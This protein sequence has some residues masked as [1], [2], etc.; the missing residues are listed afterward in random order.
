MCEPLTAHVVEVAR[1]NG[2]VSIQVL[3]SC[4]QIE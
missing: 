4:M 2:Y 3:R 1:Y